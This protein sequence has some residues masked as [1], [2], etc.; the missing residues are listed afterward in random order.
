[1]FHSYRL[2]LERFYFVARFENPSF[3]KEE[4]ES[5]VAGFTYKSIVETIFRNRRLRVE[6]EGN[7][8]FSGGASTIE[9]T[10]PKERTGQTEVKALDR[11]AVIEAL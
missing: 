8:V 5:W 3:R 1:M 10:W 7:A 11:R 2:L 6:R 9:Q 4:V